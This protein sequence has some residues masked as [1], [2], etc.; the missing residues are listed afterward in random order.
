MILAAQIAL[1]AFVAFFVFSP[2][3]IHRGEKMWVE[4]R[5]EEKRRSLK[6]RKE[7]LYSGVVELDFDRD[8]GKISIEDHARMRGELMKDVLTVLQE[9]DSLE[10][11]GRPRPTVVEGGDQ[12]ER[13]I[14]EYKRTRRKEAEAR[15]T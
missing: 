8:S 9:E 5:E 2:L 7:R 6:E 14:Q 3:V 10:R 15:G 4:T 12:V 1:I 13:M 11:G